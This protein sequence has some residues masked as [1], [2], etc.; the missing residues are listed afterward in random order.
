MVSRYAPDGS[1]DPS[2]GSGGTSEK[3][4]FEVQAV[5]ALPAGK[6][7]VAGAGILEPGGTKTL[8]TY[9]VYVARLG[10]DGK[11]EQGFGKAG[12]VKLQ[13]EDKVPGA[14]ALFI[15]AR[16]GGGAE[17]VVASMVAGLDSSGNLDPGFG[18]GG[19]VATP[20][21]AVGAGAAAGEA[22]LVAGTRPIGRPSKGEEEVPEELYVAR[23]DAA[24][25]L[26]PAY[27][28]GSGIALPDQGEEA[29]AGAALV[30]GDGSVT[31]GGDAYR[32]AGCSPGHLCENSPV[33]ARVTPAGVPDPGFGTGGI[34]R[35]TSLTVPIDEGYGVAILALAARAGGGIFA[36]GQGLG[37]TFVAALGTNGALDPGFAGSGLVTKGS[38]KPSFAS[39]VASGVDRA[40]RI[41][42]LANSNSGTGLQQSAIV[43][44]YLPDS[45]LDQ[46]YGEG[47]KAYVPAYPESLAVAPDGSVYVT[48]G[49]RSS[50][51]KLTPSGSPDPGFGKGGA[52]QL[53]SVEPFESSVL[54]TLPDGDLLVAGSAYPRALAWPAVL[55]L[56]PN[57]KVD[58]AF[59]EGGVAVARPPTGQVWQSAAAI[60]VD[61]GGHIVLAGSVLHGCCRER[62]ALVRLNPDGQ[63][64]RSFGHRGTVLFGG[65][66]ITTV[67]ALAHRGD[68]ILAITT[69]TGAHKTRDVLYAFTPK[70][71]LDRHFGTLGTAIAKTPN[72]RREPFESVSVFNTSNRII[73]AREYLSDPLV[74]FTPQGHLVPSFAR[75]LKNLVPSI[76][77]R[78]DRLGPAATLDGN[79]L[80]FAWS[81]YSAGG[82]AQGAKEGELKLRRVLLSVP[83]PS[84]PSGW[85]SGS[86]MTIAR[87][88]AAAGTRTAGS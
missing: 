9:Q 7:L 21:L 53:Q 43:L 19:R 82:S 74:A 38:K 31:V 28:D 66:G 40:G 13:S 76:P 20:G 27:A 61:R 54:T 63:P 57:G 51:V 80:V 47:G 29:S 30:G 39:P 84:T 17:V 42:V 70:G 83:W 44:R 15:Q 24:G 33:I 25:H 49:E 52:A 48:S 3:L 1:L 71:R 85:S 4:P 62:G 12:I 14:D 73:V 45:T 64:D 22:L 67:G 34:T 75:H 2:F 37:A 41:Y 68:R 36:S 8:P 32:R 88:V 6:V 18:N 59:G 77:G 72:H 16:Q 81:S 69:L 50:L 55:R 26:D 56:H 58:R 5:A 87:R 35:L 10:S 86:V 11:I 23:F 65:P 79:T 46:S 78:E 60:T